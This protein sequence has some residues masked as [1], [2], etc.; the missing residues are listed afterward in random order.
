[1]RARGGVGGDDDPARV[2]DD[3][4]LVDRFDH[5]A[6][7]LLDR[8]AFVLGPAALGRVRAHHDEAGLVAGV[9]EDVRH[10]RAHDDELAVVAAVHRLDVAHRLSRRSRRAGSTRSCSA[11]PTAT[12]LGTP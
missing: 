6:V 10:R 8:A 7:E 4:A 9:V 1:M 3:D 12:S 11:E 2:G 5:G